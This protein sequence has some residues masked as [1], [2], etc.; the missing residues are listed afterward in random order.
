M[1]PRNTK[2]QHRVSKRAPSRKNTTPAAP[3]PPATNGTDNAL[4]FWR[5][6][7]PATGYLSQWYP[8][9]FTDDTDPSIVYQTAEH[10]MMYQKALLFSAP[11]S[12]T[13]TILD[14]PHPRTARSLG[15]TVPAF[16]DAVWDAHRAAIVRRGNL[17]KFTRPA[18]GCA[19]GFWRIASGSVSSTATEKVVGTASLTLRELLLG[20]GDREIVEA[21]P[22]DRIWGIGFGAANAAR[23]GRERWGLNLLGKALVEVRGVLRKMEGEKQN[24]GGEDGEMAME[25]ERGAEEMEK[26]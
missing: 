4:Y 15:R 19:D 5:E 12:L 8:C 2:P 6:T 21:S 18:D 22:R 25:D 16:S 17:L 7:D 3:R 26:K 10:Y 14:A 9:A 11:L 23:V 20:T 1:A 24:A 13:T